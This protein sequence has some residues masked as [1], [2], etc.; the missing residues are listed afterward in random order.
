[1]IL[2]ISCVSRGGLNRGPN[3]SARPPTGMDGR[4]GTRESDATERT[5][6]FRK[7]REC[8]PAG[9]LEPVPRRGKL[10]TG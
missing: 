8:C 5:R 7:F 3:T 9:A 1:M 10:E 4:A 2:G 6:R